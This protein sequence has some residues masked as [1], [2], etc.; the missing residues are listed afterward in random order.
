[1][2]ASGTDFY[3]S[4]REAKLRKT[5]SLPP[6]QRIAKDGR[7]GSGAA[8]VGQFRVRWSGASRV[9]KEQ[10]H[11]QGDAQGQEGRARQAAAPA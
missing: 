8:K 2:K 3:K 4:I 7:G 10:P 1:M 5:R 11:C 9:L 6:M